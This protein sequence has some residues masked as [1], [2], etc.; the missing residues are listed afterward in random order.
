MKKGY[1]IIELLVMV[2]ILT[3]LASFI[4]PTY[5][6][7]LAQF[8]LTS[9]AAQVA[10]FLIL[11]EQKT[12]TE[13]KIY[14][15]TLTANA[16]TIPQFLYNPVPNPPTKTTQTTFTLPSNIIISSVNFSSNSDVRFTA[17]GAPSVSGNVVIKDTIRNR[18]RRIEVRPSGAILANTAEF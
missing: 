1:T 4:V 10:E 9:A 18:S 8:Q 7:I 11:T 14:G 15:V 3:V 6:L 5:Q 12:V 2:G 17:S 13:Q 16:S